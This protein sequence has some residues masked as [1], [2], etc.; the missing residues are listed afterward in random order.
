MTERQSYQGQELSSQEE[1]VEQAQRAMASFAESIQA[2]AEANKSLLEDRNRLFGCGV[3]GS[4][5]ANGVFHVLECTTSFSKAL[6]STSE[7]T[8][9]VQA[10]PSSLRA[11]CRV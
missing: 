1:R 4:L 10:L 11:V 6:G 2:L 8:V 7:A 5:T 3:Q 9:L